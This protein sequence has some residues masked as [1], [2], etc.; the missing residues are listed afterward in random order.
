[1]SDPVSVLTVN[2]G[3][4][5]VKAALFAA[6]GRVRRGRV[7]RLRTAPTLSLDG[8]DEALPDATD[9]EDAARRLTTILTED[10]APGAAPSVVAHRIVHGGGRD[11]PA[12]F[13]PA[14]FDELAGLVPYAPLH[15]PHGLR[16]AAALTAAMPEAAH[17]AC[18]DTAFHQ[19][20]P[21]AQTVLPLPERFG[22]PALRRYGFHG[23]SY[24]GTARWLAE[25]RP[26]LTRVVAAH[27]GSGASLCAIRA[28][29]SV[30]T[31][32]SLTPL[33][34]LPMGTRSGALDPGAVLMLAERHGAEA[35]RDALYR[36]AGLLGVSGLSND[37]RDLRA[38]DDPRAALALDLLV[39]RTAEGVAGMAVAAGGLDALVFSGGVGEN[40]EAFRDAVARRLGF[41]PPFETLVRP[42]EEE[43]VMARQ[44]RR[45][46]AEA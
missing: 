40:D 12:R 44:A 7:T 29:R 23:L 15:Q 9:A 16:I 5:S 45:L 11:G 36:E 30:G 6:D 34:G 28:G 33:D 37:V 2:A 24:E 43:A 25:A 41:F 18:F 1:M 14:L 17:V 4:S 35:V 26:D 8:R 46:L 22:A 20:M 21:E 38:S 39:Q 27:I 13:T 19:T 10:A 42:A 32:M 31:S 3:S